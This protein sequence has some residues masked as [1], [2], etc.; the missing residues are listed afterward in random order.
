MS[1]QNLPP[2][3]PCLFFWFASLEW[4]AIFDGVSSSKFD[5]I[6]SA[7]I[8]I[9]Q[10]RK[11]LIQSNLFSSI[12]GISD[13]KLTLKL[14]FSNTSV[15]LQAGEDDCLRTKRY[16]QSSARR[17]QLLATT[18]PPPPSTGGSLSSYTETDWVSLDLIWTFFASNSRKRSFWETNWTN[19]ILKS[20]P[21]FMAPTL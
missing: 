20:Y 19:R 10:M 15:I 6:V 12:C 3:L 18:P 8:K 11:S 9:L 2:G 1:L 5:L 7:K 13:A 21:P 4:N 16:Y 17:S 14:A